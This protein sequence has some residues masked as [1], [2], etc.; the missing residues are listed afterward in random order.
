MLSYCYHHHFRWLEKFHDV[1]ALDPNIVMFVRIVDTV[2]IVQSKEELVEY[3]NRIMNG[4][5]KKGTN[6][7][8]I[9]GI[10]ILLI[11]IYAIIKNLM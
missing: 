6:T 9:A 4:Y 1:D 2:N 3:V 8:K 5:H 7:L 11:A 10:G